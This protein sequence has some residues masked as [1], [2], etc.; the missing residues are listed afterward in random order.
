MMVGTILEV[1]S[2]EQNSKDVAQAHKEREDM[3]DKIAVMKTQLD[4][5]ESLLKNKR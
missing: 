3:A 4:V 2:A 1:M 5:I